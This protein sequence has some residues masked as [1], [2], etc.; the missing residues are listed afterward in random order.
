MRPIGTAPALRPVI[1][2]IPCSEEQQRDINF[3]GGYLTDFVDAIESNHAQAR[4]I[5][6]SDT[7]PEAL[8]RD[9]DALLIPGGADV[10]PQLYGVNLPHT[11]RTPD[12][13][14][15]RF[16]YGLVQY[17]LGTQMPMLGICRGQ[18]MMNVAAGGSLTRDINSEMRRNV[19]IEHQYKKNSDPTIA[20]NERALVH[21]VVLARDQDPCGMTDS[22][23]R[24]LFGV[25]RMAVNSAH[26]QAVKALGPI[27]A[28]TAWAMDGVIEGI[29][30]K[31]NHTQWAVQWHPERQW[32]VDGSSNCMFQKLIADGQHYRFGT[33]TQVAEAPP[34]RKRRARKGVT[35]L[36][37]RG[38]GNRDPAIAQLFPGLPR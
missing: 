21:D 7:P 24:R 38:E 12:P 16:E 14:F 32:R 6:T 13:A 18:Q 5:P 15:D 28:V 20:R 2:G 11:S 17:A 29:E 9:V 4:L 35:V 19:F 22:N 10:D 33:A 3:G 25:D 23:L 27:F 34:A 37:I 26:H 1:V 8:L 30:R 36:Q 31:D